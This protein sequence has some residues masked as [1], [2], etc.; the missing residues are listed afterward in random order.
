MLCVNL[1]D[2]FT[3][4]KRFSLVGSTEGGSRDWGASNATL[5]AALKRF[6][7]LFKRPR[8]TLP[9]R[10]LSFDRGW[11]VVRGRVDRSS[12]WSSGERDTWSS[13][14]WL[15]TKNTHSELQLDRQL[16]HSQKYGLIS[17]S[18]RQRHPNR[19]RPQL[20][21]NLDLRSNPRVPQSIVRISNRWDD[22]GPLSMYQ[23]MHSWECSSR[24]KYIE[25]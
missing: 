5:G 18:L 14:T 20:I 21:P 16:V 9:S 11:R 2:V 6:I 1:R 22:Q 10:A 4:D 25:S 23:S 12:Q 8:R 17:F 7:A 19:Y 15:K 3:L 13:C 24:P